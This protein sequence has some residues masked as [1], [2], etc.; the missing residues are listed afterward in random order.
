MTGAYIR[1]KR[2]GVIITA[3]LAVCLIYRF[4]VAVRMQCGDFN[5]FSLSEW[6]INLQGGFVRRGVLGETVYRFAVTFG[7][8]PLWLIVVLSVSAYIAVFVWLY[9]HFKRVGA[10][11]W[12]LA[13]PMLMG[14][15]TIIRKDYLMMLL[16]IA[17]LTL[18][19]CRESPTMMR[20]VAAV[21]LGVVG[22]FIHESFIFWGFPA[23][24]MVM[25]A[26]RK[27][28][29][30]NISLLALVVVAAM[31]TAVYKGDADVARDIATSWNDS[32][33]IPQ[34]VD[35]NSNAVGALA[36]SSSYAAQLHTTLNFHVP[37]LGAWGGVL[38]LFI[39]LVLYYMI[40]NFGYVFSDRSA[41]QKHLRDCRAT[42]FIIFMICMLP[43]FTV[44]SCDYC[45]LYRSVAV[46]VFICIFAVSSAKLDAMLPSCLVARVARLND[47]ISC[48]IVP[49]RGLM[50]ILLFV[51]APSPVGCDL[52]AALHSTLVANILSIMASTAEHIT[53]LL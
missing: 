36:W 3:L 45:R 41:A 26:E 27:H 47:I 24:V 12:I 6:L 33:L 42:L 38:R 37:G 11:W 52:S 7:C 32:G 31:V 49:T 19:G 51:I 9:R 44:L 14:E 46:S 40:A 18:V 5:D 21:M 13:S 39:P 53:S 17:M 29:C 4:I 16:M 22:V 30:L 23:L 2:L 1:S 43:M 8:S 15:M 34:H 10:C 35:D 48:Q 20:K 25:L 28:W 50:L